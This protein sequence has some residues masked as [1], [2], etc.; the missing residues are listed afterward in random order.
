MTRIR[1][2]TNTLFQLFCVFMVHLLLKCLFVNIQKKEIN[3]LNYVVMV[4]DFMR[5]INHRRCF[6]LAE[7]CLD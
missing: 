3:M 5:K 4:E 2:K 1:N 6:H 7:S